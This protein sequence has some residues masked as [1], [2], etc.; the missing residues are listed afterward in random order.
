M[1]I[2]STIAIVLYYL[3]NYYLYEKLVAEN[4]AILMQL[5]GI[6]STIW[7]QGNRVFLNEFEIQRMCTGVQVMAV[8]LG[9]LVAVPKVALKKRILVF[10]VV[11][12]SVH[13]ANIGRAP[14]YPPQE[15]DLL[16]CTTAPCHLC[17]QRPSLLVTNPS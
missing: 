5:I 3:P 9:I 17:T 10:S 15:I 2:A 8:F 7:T 6:K 14:A 1:V 4:S 16:S 11:A 13:M 12:V